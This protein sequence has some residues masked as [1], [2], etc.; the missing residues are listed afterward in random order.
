MKNGR[1]CCSNRSKRVLFLSGVSGHFAALAPNLLR[2]VTKFESENTRLT[3]PTVADITIIGVVVFVSTVF[4][5]WR[6]IGSNNFLAL[7]FL[8]TFF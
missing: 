1:P 8:E 5:Y 7:L 6:R 3:A 2:F 4:V